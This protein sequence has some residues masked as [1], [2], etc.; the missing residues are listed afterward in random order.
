MRDNDHG[1]RGLRVYLKKFA[2]AYL[3]L[4]TGEKNLDSGG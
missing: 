2:A 4:I 1:N 3:G